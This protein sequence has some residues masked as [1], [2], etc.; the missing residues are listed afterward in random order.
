MALTVKTMSAPDLI[1][2]TVPTNVTATDVSVTGFTLTW[3]E[4][5]DNLKVS[6]YE[7]YRN[8][9]LIGTT[10]VPSFNV[11]DVT[12]GTTYSMAVLAVDE[13]KNKS[14]L[15]GTLIVSVKD[16]LAPS[17]PI[18]IKSSEMT[19]T[20]F[21][22][23]WEA[24]TDNVKVTGYNV[25]RNGTYIASTTGTSHTFTGL[26]A[27]TNVSITILAYDA[28]KNRSALSTPLVVKVGE[29]ADT[30]APSKPA[31]LTVS[32]MTTTGFRVQ[33]TAATDN[34]GV[35]AYNVYQNGKY[36]KTVTETGYTFS[37]L[38][39]NTAY[40]ITVLAMDAAKNR[41]LLSDA[42]LVQTV[43]GADT[44]APSVP[45]GVL[46]SSVTSGSFKVTWTA[47]SDN[48]GVAGY[49]VY[50]NGA[51][52]GT[53]TGT[54]YNFSGLAKNTTFNITILAFDAAKNRSAHSQ[55]LA[56]TTTP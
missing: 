34:V 54:F 3:N 6:R 33:W 28:A 56:V 45:L 48:V 49:N 9:N 39:A 18:G 20:G 11:T 23:S 36:V 32:Q 37:G 46:A 27:G 44:A 24:S 47:A 53:T 40:S 8:G 10:T 42:L 29:T 17:I 5:S 35:T 43:A 38:L 19:S 50:R 21:R 31:G 25:Y 52:V 16:Q 55:A 14:A 30:T 26:T 15:S 22:V 13:A 41:S 12:V 7:V 51:Y 4:S 1:P 2:P